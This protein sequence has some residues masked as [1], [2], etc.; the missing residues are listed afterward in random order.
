METNVQTQVVAD[1]IPQNPPTHPLFE[2]EEDE[3]SN[4]ELARSYIVVYE[5]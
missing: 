2:E 3:I 4:K 5:S 1:Q